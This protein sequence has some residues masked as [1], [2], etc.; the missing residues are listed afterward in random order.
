MEHKIEINHE[1]RE[2]RWLDMITGKTTLCGIKPD[3]GLVALKIAGYSSYIDRASG[4]RYSPT[5]FQVHK[6]RHVKTI[7]NQVDLIATTSL[8]GLMSWNLKGEKD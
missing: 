8:F 1:T 3:E 7:S 4:T 5:C 2:C 6:Y